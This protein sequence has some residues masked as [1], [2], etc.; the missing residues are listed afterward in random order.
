MVKRHISFATEARIRED[1]NISSKTNLFEVQN[2]NQPEIASLLPTG[3][4]GADV[5][6]SESENASKLSDLLIDRRK[7]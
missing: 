6:N 4:F 5:P 7:R 3:L 1:Y 2:A